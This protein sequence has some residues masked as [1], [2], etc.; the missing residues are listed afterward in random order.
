MKGKTRARSRRED[1]RRS[2]EGRCTWVVIPTAVGVRRH[3]DLNARGKLVGKGRNVRVRRRRWRVSIAEVR[4][5]GERDEGTRT[6]T[7]ARRSMVARKRT[8]ERGRNW[9]DLPAVQRGRAMIFIRRR[10]RR[11]ETSTLRK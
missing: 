9:A 7:K 1:A 5:D 10:V 8:Q 11:K 2:D 4:L 6:E 3:D